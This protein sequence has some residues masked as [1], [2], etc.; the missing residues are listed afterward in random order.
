MHRLAPAF[1][2]IGILAATPAATAPAADPNLY[3]EQVDGARALAKV[4][5]WNAETLAALEK[6]PGFAEYRAKALALLSTNQKIAEPDQILGGKV[7]NFWQDEQHPRGIW[8]VS[9]LAAFAAG[10]PQWRTLLDIDAMSKA[11]NKKWVF[12]GATCLSP[13]YVDCMV[14]LSNGGGDAVEVREFDLEKAAFVPNGFFLPNAGVS[15]AGVNP[16]VFFNVFN[17]ANFFGPGSVDGNI[18]SPTFGQIVQANAPRLVQLGV[19]Y[20]F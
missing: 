7:L 14:S 4:K 5:S 18:V 2:T 9:P 1:A 19:K 15:V 16:G 6:Q 8:R 17:Q 20:S 12:K 3:L 10:Q 13:A 11:D